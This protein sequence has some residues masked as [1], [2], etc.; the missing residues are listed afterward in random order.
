MRQFAPI[1]L[2]LLLTGNLV[3]ASSNSK[4]QNSIQMLIAELC[5]DG[6][7]SA[8]SLEDMGIVEQF[9]LAILVPDGECD[10]NNDEGD[11]SVDEQGNLV[12]SSGNNVEING[13]TVK[14][15]SRSGNLV[16]ENGDVVTTADNKP[17]KFSN[18]ARNSQGRATVDLK[19]SDGTSVPDIAVVEVKI[20]P[21]AAVVITPVPSAPSA[22]NPEAAP[23]PVADAPPPPPIAA[24]PVAPRPNLTPRVPQLPTA[25]IESAIIG[26][27]GLGEAQQNQAGSPNT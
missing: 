25:A 27:E 1:I 5:L 22:T 11:Y 6:N 17:I 10:Q 19:T 21:P 12:D 4:A 2:T 16:T 20:V 26:A 7:N 24:T 14:V 23:A 9:Q 3:F 13:E 15:D 18:K 8:C